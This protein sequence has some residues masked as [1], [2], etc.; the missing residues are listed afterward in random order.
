MHCKNAMKRHWA[1]AALP[2]LLN[3]VAPQAQAQTTSSADRPSFTIHSAAG[4]QAERGFSVTLE[5]ENKQ[6]FEV[7]LPELL[8]Q[9]AREANRGTIALIPALDFVVVLPMPE[10]ALLNRGKL[11]LLSEV[12]EPDHRLFELLP[13]GSNNRTYRRV[14]GVSVKT[15]PSGTS[16]ELDARDALSS[17]N[18]VCVNGMSGYQFEVRADSGRGFLLAACSNFNS[19]TARALDP[20]I[21]GT[22]DVS[23]SY[24]IGDT[25]FRF[26][27]IHR[28]E[29]WNPDTGAPPLSE[30]QVQAVV[31]LL[32]RAVIFEDIDEMTLTAAFLMASE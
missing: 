22:F 24:V 16:A 4:V 6:K 28:S 23:M 5:T 12:N 31:A 7:Y 30:E 11:P 29:S 9:M 14:H 27:S 17:L 13:A 8:V 26:Y 20:S 32:D 15:V 21:R 18:S 1:V 2:F 19:M 3:L 25:A 10:F